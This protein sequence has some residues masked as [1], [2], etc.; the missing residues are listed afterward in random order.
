[1][2]DAPLEELLET[3]FDVIVHKIN[4]MNL[5]LQK[6]ITAKFINIKLL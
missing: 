4:T 5:S 3:A 2:I 6:D 1:M